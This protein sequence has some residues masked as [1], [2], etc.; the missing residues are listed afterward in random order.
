MV[1]DVAHFSSASNIQVYRI[2]QGL[3]PDTLKEGGG[4][5][6]GDSGLDTSH[7]SKPLSCNVDT[8][9]SQN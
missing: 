9:G 3:K 8:F 2:T 7:R 5:R 4:V 6:R 1:T